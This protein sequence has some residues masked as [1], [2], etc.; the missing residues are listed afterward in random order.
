MCKE[1]ATMDPYPRHRLQATEYRRSSTFRVHTVLMCSR[2]YYLENEKVVRYWV[3]HRPKKSCIGL[4]SSETFLTGFG[5]TLLESVDPAWAPELLA[6][7]G[8]VVYGVTRRYFCLPPRTRSSLT[9]SFSMPI[10]M[11]FWKRQAW[12]AFRRRLLISQS[13]DAGHVYSMFPAMKFTHT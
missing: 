1:S 13:L 5:L 9:P 10:R 7:A 12:Q 6:D 4:P 8:V 2:F 3:Q 11:H